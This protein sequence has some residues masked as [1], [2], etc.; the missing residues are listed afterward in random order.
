M[1]LL[2]PHIILLSLLAAAPIAA[3]DLSSA[4]QESLSKALSEA[5]NSPIEFVRAIENHLKTYPN[6]PKKLEL[7]RALVKTAIDLNDDRRISQFGEIVLKQEPD[8]LQIL[9]R[10]TTALLHNGDKGSAERALVHSIHFDE[11][12]KSLYRFD[13]FDPGAGHEAAKRKDDFDRAQARAKLMLARSH[14]LLGHSAEAI[15]FAQASYSLYPSVEGAREAAR[16][17]SAAGKEQ[18]SIPYLAA[19]VAISGL[20]STDPDDAG[21]RVK[22]A[23][24][25][26]KLHGSDAGLGD[27]LLKAFDNTSAQFATRRARLREIDPNAQIKD[28]LRFTLSAPGGEKLQLASLNGKVIVLDFWA[29]WCGPCRQQHPLYDTVKARYKDRDDVVFL[30]IDTDDDHTLVKP[31]LEAQKW[32]QMVYFEDGLSSLLQVSSI[33]M[34]VVYNKKGE[35]VSRM[36][37]FVPERFVEMLAERIDDALGLPHDAQKSKVASSQ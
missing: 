32:T 8:N 18:E 28:P 5:G 13:K 23:E 4:E 31:F 12:V 1:K 22:M 15:Q 27:V 30:S 11:V 24:L 7:E 36:P 9:E 14:G 10:V 20:R 37:G 6:S 19:V 33:P 35:V 34:T 16:W 26:R 21:D 17:L 29:T 2:Y 3:Q 25:Y